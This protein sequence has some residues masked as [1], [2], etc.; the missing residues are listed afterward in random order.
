MTRSDGVVDTREYDALD[1]FLW[2]L[3]AVEP[4]VMHK[5][6]IDGNRYRIAGA[7]VL[8][9][10]LF[11]TLAWIYFF[12]IT[13]TAAWAFVP[14]GII[15]GGIVLGI[16]RA[17]IKGISKAAKLALMP[18][19]LRG[20]LALTIGLFMAQPAVLYLF[21]KEVSMQASI[22]NEG[23]RQHKRLQLDSLYAGELRDL[24]HQKITL[25]QSLS[26]A[27]AQVL[28]AQK[29]FLAE[30][31]GTGGSRQLGISTI[32]L[33]KKEAYQALD[34]QYKQQQE[35][36]QPQLDALE[37]RLNNIANEKIMQEKQF[38]TL[39]NAGFLTRIEAL[40][41]LVTANKAVAFRYYLIVAILMLIEL[42]PVIVK[43]M[44]PAGPYDA[45]V[46]TIE[47]NETHL[48]Q[49]EQQYQSE[50]AAAKHKAALASD[51]MA[52][53]RFYEAADAARASSADR[54]VAEWQQQEDTGF[55]QL[56]QSFKHRVLGAFKS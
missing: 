33:A 17:L 35:Q 19:I 34:Q 8:G 56:L 18:L 20:L 32:A 39:L 24:Q 49:L 9:T 15:M 22:D 43:A 50:L 6:V 38:A 26:L 14:L 47:K 13:F 21:N 40:H 27:S 4:T 7:V 16:D 2:W 48:F 55:A 51:S 30:T 42:M 12:Y 1:A 36:L 28:A 11:A 54:I 37:V 23:R 3:A 25:L 53:Q 10:W 41:H 44:M 5:F 31:D 46:A 29:A 45:A 52:I